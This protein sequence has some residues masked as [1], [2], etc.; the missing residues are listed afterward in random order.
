MTL[1]RRQTKGIEIVYFLLILLC[2]LLYLDYK[3]FNN[4]KTTMEEKNES[5][6]R[7]LNTINGIFLLIIAVS[8]NFTAEVLSCRMRKLLND[9][10][11]AKNLVII[12]TIYFSLGFV[13]IQS[14]LSPIDLLRRSIVIWIFFL[15]FNRMKPVNMYI[16]LFLII[17]ILVIRNWID[18]LTAKDEEK[19]EKT[20]NLL[21]DIT[22]GLFLITSMISIYGFYDYLHQKIKDHSNYGLNNTFNYYTFIFGKVDCDSITS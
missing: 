6:M 20:I 18:Y 13:D 15:I 4:K 19:Y 11:Y 17:N 16:V 8:G 21:F 3:K 5:N 7:R 2:V 1:L 10:M 9:N 22:D 12:S 14:N